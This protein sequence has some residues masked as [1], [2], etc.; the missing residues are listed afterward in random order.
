MEPTVLDLRTADLAALHAIPQH[1]LATALHQLDSPELAGLFTRLGDEQLAEL[2]AELEPYDA[3]RLI[4]KLSRGQAADLLEEMDPDDAADVVGELGP[5]EAEAIIVAMQPAEAEDLRELLAYPPES[6]GG[7][8]TPEYV[9]ISPDLT[10][11]EALLTLRR[12]AE[13]AETI[14]YI[15]VTEPATQRLLGVLSLR[16]LVLSRPTTPVRDLMI[17]D[18]V[19]VRADAAS[20]AAARLLDRYHL[21]ALPVVDDAERL[22]GIITADDAAGVLLEEAGEDLE[23]LGGSQPLEEPYLRASVLHLFRKRI[24][25]L[26]VL[27][28]AEAYTGSVLRYF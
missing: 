21:I 19:K 24:A 12:V 22:L 1:D 5:G 7:L 20:E 14:Y 3:A 23:R 10:A 18:A 6:A 11:D 25:W 28:V 8:M 16:N 26:L 4:G 27:F 13:E 17:R 15:Y 2:L 9:A